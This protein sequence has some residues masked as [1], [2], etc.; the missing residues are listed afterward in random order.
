MN[1]YPFSIGDYAR[2]TRHLSW[3]EDIAYRR[4]IDIY[5]EREAPLPADKRQI[6]R[7][8]MATCA[9]H[10]QAIEAVLAE[11][12]TLGDDGYHNSRCDEEIERFRKKGAKAAQSAEARWRNANASRGE[13]ITHSEGNA[14]AMRTHSEGNANQEPRTKNQERVITET[15]QP[16]DLAPEAGRCSDLETKLRKAAGWEPEPHPMLAVTGPIEALIAA[17]ASLERDV[18]PVIAALA[19]KVRGRSGWKYFVGPI[20]DAM[21]TRIAAGQSPQAAANV[22]DRQRRKA[23]AARRIEEH[24]RMVDEQRARSQHG[25]G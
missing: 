4:M 2:A 5:Y 13:A 22:E 7:L 17:G 20:R 14:D 6:F 15:A 24:N 16:Y 21:A 18:L 8:L 12:F 3:D 23:E 9:R 10:K 25:A 1:F 11:F 19:P